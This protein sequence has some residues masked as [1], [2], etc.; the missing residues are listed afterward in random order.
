[1]KRGEDV[2]VYNTFT[3]RWAGGFVVEEPVGV[4]EP[5]GYRVRRVSEPEV[6]PAVIDAQQVR[7][8]RPEP[9]RPS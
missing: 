4:P 1:M 9:G 7:P 3:G 6:L 5:S 2:E 8:A